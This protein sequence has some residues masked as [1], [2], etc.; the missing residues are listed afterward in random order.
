MDDR[1]T[2]LISYVRTSGVRTRSK[3]LAGRWGP[4]RTIAGT[5]AAD[6]EYVRTVLNPAGTY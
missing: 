3:P 5:G 2:A 1:G 6:G 4:S